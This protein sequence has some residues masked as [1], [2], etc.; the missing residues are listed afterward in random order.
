MFKL[1]SNFNVQLVQGCLGKDKL[2]KYFIGSKLSKI[3]GKVW[4]VK[5]WRF[6]NFKFFKHRRTKLSNY[7]MFVIG[8]DV[9]GIISEKKCSNDKLKSLQFK[10]RNKFFYRIYRWNVHLMYERNRQN[11]SWQLESYSESYYNRL[12]KCFKRCKFNK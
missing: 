10:C 5:I 2:F 12:F 9:F 6:S 8:S 1:T 3:S 11:I 4:F 7:I